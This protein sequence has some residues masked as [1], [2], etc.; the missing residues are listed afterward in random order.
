MSF[1][2]DAEIASIRIKQMIVHVVGGKEKFEPQ[3]VMEGVEHIDFF[4]ARIQDAAASGVHRFQEKSE[5]K[6]LLQQIGSQKVSFENGAQE[7]SRR[8][9]NDHVGSSRDGAFFVFELETGDPQTMLYSL[10]KY[11]YRQAIELYADKGRNALRQIVHAFVREKRAIQKSC[12]VR[13]RNGAVEDGV[14][15]IDRMGDSPDLTDYFQ[16]FLEVVR[17]R[18]TKELSD[19]LNEVLRST[20]QKCKSQLPNQ[21]VPSAVA[22]TKDFLRGRENVDDESIREALF[23]AAGRPG[24]EVRAEIDKVLSKQLKEKRLA[25][26]SFRPDPNSLR[27]APRRKIQTAEGVVLLYPGEQENRAVTREPSASGGWTITIKTAERLVEDGTVPERT[28]ADA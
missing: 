7:L 12:L 1:L 25:G 9:S 17:D 20:L 11:D 13:V 23:I 3:P 16:K 10:I 24:E 4:L 21:D 27:R 18:D 22:A 6:A 26:V 19:R 8:F 5:T 15:A 28:R 2:T 14:S